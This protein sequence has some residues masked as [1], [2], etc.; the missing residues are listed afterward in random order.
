M[1]KSDDL[2]GIL[3]TRE[4]YWRSGC[5]SEEAVDCVFWMRSH[6]A[7]SLQKI[8]KTEGRAAVLL[9]NDQ[10]SLKIIAFVIHKAALRAIEKF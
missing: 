7:Y 1:I 3:F 9:K 4:P 2:P 5:K 8:P 10:K 6:G